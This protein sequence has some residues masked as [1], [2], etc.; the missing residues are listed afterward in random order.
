MNVF[1]SAGMCMTKNVLP[2]QETS[3]FQSPHLFYLSSVL[4]IHRIISSLTESGKIITTLTLAAQEM[5]V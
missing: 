3:L 2:P 1:L 4:C 5:L